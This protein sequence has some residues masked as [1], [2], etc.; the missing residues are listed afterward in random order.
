[1]DRIEPR[2]TMRDLK[3]ELAR[4]FLISL[5]ATLC[6]E[7]LNQRSFLR[8][9]EFIAYRPW[10]LLYDVLILADFLSLGMLFKRRFAVTTTLL[11]F[12]LLMAVVNFAV[13]FYRT[14]PFTTKDF[15][16]IPAG[17]SIMPTYFNPVQIVLIFGALVGLVA[18]M[19]LLFLRTGTKPRTHFWA[20]LTAIVCFT[21]FL[22]G[23]H[24]AAVYGGVMEK[25]M[26]NLVTAY[27]TYGFTYCFT[28][29][30]ASIGIPKPSGYNTDTVT[31]IVTELDDETEVEPTSI[32]ASEE[33]P[34]IIYLQLESH[35]DVPVQLL[36]AEFSEDPIP[37][38]TALK[39][40]YP[41][42]QLLVP[43]VGGGTVNTEFEILSGMN[44][45]YFGAGEIPYNTVLNNTTCESICYNLAAHD[46]ACTALHN[47]MGTFYGRNTV[48]SQLGFDTFASMEYMP[49]LEF[50]RTGWPKDA[51]LTQ[52]ILDALDATHSRDFIMTITVQSHGKYLDTLPEDYE[53]PVKVL[54]CPESVNPISL[55]NYVNELRE[56]DDFVAALL[57]ELEARREPTIVVMYGDH[58][59]GLGMEDEDMACG[60]VYQTTYIIW[61]NFG[62]KF[63]APDLQAYRLSANLLRQLNIDTGLLTRFHQAAPVDDT[64]EEYLNA[65]EILEY[66]MLY[67]DHESTGGEVPHVAKKLKLGVRPIR[68]TDAE[69]DPEKGTLTVNGENF[70]E[71]SV[72]VFNGERLETAFITGETLVAIPDNLAVESHVCVAQV[73]KENIELSRTRNYSIEIPEAL[74][75]AETP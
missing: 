17:L 63:E 60:S 47:Y 3:E 59:P 1:M 40:K 13:T 75:A 39:K 8:V 54:A 5:A 46:Y 30:C 9:F 45:D 58:L 28:R 12:A 33:L 37:T 57:T 56:V 22:V 7:C 26:E 35:F 19:V 73:T 53:N 15:L 29:T 2:K 68:I 64:S 6:I 24:F 34:N 65:L 72:V 42:G 16:L 61:N 32:R 55:E 44:L 23:I 11:G 36:G 71:S 31:Q 62:A 52:E 21:A 38:F 70:T 41:Y 51:R 50:N 25:R 20:K 69:Y 66:D 74:E 48:Y 43:S 18:G 49:G 27:K 4:F 14:Q 10:M 67:G